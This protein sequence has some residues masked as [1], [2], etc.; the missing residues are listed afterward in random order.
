MRPRDGCNRP[1]L[2]QPLT[3]EVI[4]MT[5]ATCSIS[6][7]ERPVKY[8]AAQ[9]CN[10]HYL[11]MRSGKDLSAP[12][13]K[14][15][16]T[17]DEALKHRVRQNG[18]CLEW[19]GFRNNGYGRG[20]HD[21]DNVYVHR[22]VYEKNYGPIPNGLDVD[23]ICGNRSCCNPQHLRAVTPKQNSENRGAEKGSRSGYRGVAWSS[24]A[25]AW[26]ARVFHAGRSFYLGTFSTAEEANLVVVA[27][28]NRLY[29]HNDSDR[30]KAS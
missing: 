27:E 28:R 11:R 5:N 14:I 21:G 4:A 3:K 22:Y 20:W 1:G 10:L 8:K 17:L 18:D 23:H 29:T 9:M 25:N 7:C 30:K 24:Q 26:V 13:R 19:T 15:Y 6:D 2:W 16:G 12:A